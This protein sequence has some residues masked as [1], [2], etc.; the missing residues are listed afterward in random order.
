MQNKEDKIFIK[1]DNLYN[2][3]YHYLP[4]KIEDKVFK[5]F[6]VHY[7]LYD[8]IFL[9]NF[10]I[11]KIKKFKHDNLLDFG[12][13]DG[14]FINDL[15]RNTKI[16]LFGYEISVQASSLFKA[17][18]PEAK[19]INSIDE[20]KKYQDFFDAINFSEVIEH[21]P[22]EKILENIDVIYKILKKDGFLMVTA[23]HENNPV[24]K[25]HYRHYNF[26]SLLKN[27]D[28]SKFEVIEKKFLF[29]SN[30]F[31]TIF[32]KLL[33]NRFFIINSNF[34]FKIFY[35]LNN[36]FFLSEEKN[37]HTIFILLKKK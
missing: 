15:K 23:P 36:F 3:P 8:Y 27:F 29:K 6:R 11:E 10:L 1:Q 12:C 21:I 28:T 24:H 30:I 35:Y 34:I 19:L 4:Q 16:F 33:F 31:K 26:E 22:S 14:R 20:L 9:I 7:W 32:R 37:C 17:F 2:F 13:G 25:K 18:N 5:P